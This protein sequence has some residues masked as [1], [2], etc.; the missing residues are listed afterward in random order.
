MRCC[1][2]KEKEDRGRSRNKCVQ[3]SWTLTLSTDGH[4]LDALAADIVQSFVHVG[5][6][7]ET[8]LALVRFGQPLACETSQDSA[9]LFEFQM[10]SDYL[11]MWSKCGRKL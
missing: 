9:S 6:L 3:I 5:D 11:L 2:K 7:V 10:F 4:Q 8:H 1:V